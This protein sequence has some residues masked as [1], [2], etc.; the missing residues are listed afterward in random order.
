MRLSTSKHHDTQLVRGCLPE[1]ERLRYRL[2]TSSLSSWTPRG[3]YQKHG[4]VV[5]GN[6]MTNFLE[7]KLTEA[8]LNSKEKADFITFWAP[9]L[10]QN[11]HTFI[12]FLFNERADDFAKLKIVPQPDNLYR[13]YMVWAEVDKN[14]T[15]EEQK[16]I[17]I[18]RTGFTA[19][20]WGGFELHLDEDAQR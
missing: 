20:E 17:P 10:S 13:I 16:I 9:K 15:A 14:Y 5:E 3:C 6:E 11:E 4:F 8:G 12:Q 7:N 1:C 2:R 19:L 18:N